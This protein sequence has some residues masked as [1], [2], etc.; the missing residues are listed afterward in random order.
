MLRICNLDLNT[1]VDDK[2][3]YSI[4]SKIFDLENLHSFIK[5]QPFYPEWREDI[6]RMV[7][8]RAAHGTVAIEGSDVKL[9]EM[10]NVAQS[11]LLKSDREKEPKNA[12]KAYEFIKEWSFNN[13]NNPISEGVISQIHTTL[14]RDINYYLNDPGKY[15]DQKVSFGDPRQESVLKNR[16]EVIDEMEKVVKFINLRTTD[17]SDMAF[18]TIPKAVITHYLITRVHPFIDGN[19]RVARTVESL[20]LHHLGDFEPYCFPSTAEFYYKERKKYMEL[21]RQTDDTGDLIPL[22]LFAIQGLHDN[23]S[24]TKKHMLDKITQT[25]IMDYSHQLRRNKKLLKRQTALLEIMFDLDPMLMKEFSQHPYIKGLYY[26]RTPYTEKRDIEKLIKYKLLKIDKETKKISVNWDALKQ[27]T[28]RLNSI[29]HRP[30]I[31]L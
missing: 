16:F 28:F 11:K 17:S 13:K 2:K 12:L 20:I 27:L 4:I 8:Y 31:K 21:L 3:K 29:P 9:D 18:W 30:E 24:K 19:G 15:R 7:L 10:D 5:D 1:I 26:E 23:L 14:T 22:V 25:L 6:E